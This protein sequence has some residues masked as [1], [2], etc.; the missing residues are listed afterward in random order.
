MSGDLIAT[1]LF[2]E[3]D[4]KQTEA[5]QREM[6]HRDEVFKKELENSDLRFKLKH[7]EVLKRNA[8]IGANEQARQLKS[9][10]NELQEY[11]ELLSKPLHEIAARH[12]TFRE[13]YEEQQTL[14]AQWIVSQ[15]AFKQLAKEYG[16]KL[17][18]S[19]EEITNNFK[20]TKV[21]VTNDL[22]N[23][24]ELIKRNKEKILDKK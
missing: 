16:E 22:S 14:L 3:N 21:K 17:G 5:I 20:D 24:D 6:D 10:I 8:E 11:D 23:T 15:R 9:K 13:R 7:Q 1:G 18:L 19:E 2:L 4:R 12:G